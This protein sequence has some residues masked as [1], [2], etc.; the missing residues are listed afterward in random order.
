MAEV[1]AAKPDR[2]AAFASLSLQSPALAVQQ[3]EYAIKKLGLKGAAI[4]GSVQG[5]DFSDPQFH[6][7][8]AKA[9]ELGAVLLIHSRSTPE[10]A[11]RFRGNGWL[12]NLIGN[13]LD[14]TIALQHSI[15]DGTVDRFP[16]LKAL[17]AHGG[18]YRGRSKR[19]IGA[20]AFCRRR[21]PIFRL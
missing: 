7:V 1:C 8:W 11:K 9:K 14:T 4:G 3:L 15:F 16:G 19:A 21:N 13:P 17:A 20:T 10:L 6:P 12:S 2:F 18:G 5:T